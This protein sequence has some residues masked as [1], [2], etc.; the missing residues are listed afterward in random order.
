MGVDDPDCFTTPGKVPTS[1]PDTVQI[2]IPSMLSASGSRTSPHSSRRSMS[3]T[4]IRKW[5]SQPWESMWEQPATL[6]YGQELFERRPAWETWQQEHGKR[7]ELILFFQN[8]HYAMTAPKQHELST[9]QHLP[10]EIE[11]YVSTKSIGPVQYPLPMA[12]VSNRSQ[13]TRHF[14]S[15]QAICVHSHLILHSCSTTLALSRCRSP[16]EVLA[17]GG[18]KAWVRDCGAYL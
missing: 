8:A 5:S 1:P 11:F 12:C 17:N 16:E 10:E 2:E 7:P 9:F 6:K 3:S 18:D 13:T 15:V 4:R 14:A